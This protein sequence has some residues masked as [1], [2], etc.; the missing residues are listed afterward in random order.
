MAEPAKE[1]VYQYVRNIIVEGKV[2][3]GT[4]IEE[5]DISA[6]IG[7]SRT[8]V[9]EAFLRLEAERF[10]DLIPRRGALVRQ[11]TADELINVY[12]VRRLIEIYAARRICEDLSLDLPKGMDELISAM[13]KAADE[14]DYLEHIQIDMEFHRRLVATTHNEVFLEMYDGLQGRRLPVAYAAFKTNPKRSTILMAQ[15]HA[16]W[17]A[18]QNRNGDEAEEILKEHLRPVFEIVS[19]LPAR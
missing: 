12:E 7:V 3:G 17:K 18:L 2:A 9:R 19:A 5:Q 13:Q 8:P 6:K 4:F 16:L 14:G 1:R 10:L 15:H 11:V